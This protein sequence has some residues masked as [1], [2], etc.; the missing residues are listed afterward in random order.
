MVVKLSHIDRFVEKPAFLNQ[1][2]YSYAMIHGTNIIGAKY[3]LAEALVRP[4]DWSYC[5]QLSK[6]EQPAYGCFALGSCVTSRAGEIPNWN[7]VDL[8]DR[9][10]T[11]GKGQQDILL[12]LQY[13][14]AKEHLALKAGGNDMVQVQ[15]ALRGVVT[16]SEKYTVA[17]SEHYTIRSLIVVWPDLS[18]IE[19]RQGQSAT[20]TPDTSKDKSKETPDD[21]QDDRPPPD[22]LR[23]W[24]RRGDQFDDEDET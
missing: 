20:Y 17:R 4:A 12:A 9:A 16:T 18:F 2:N 5:E 21:S 6:C 8:L 22:E 10:T 13:K 15:C 3:C 24:N 23:S 19:S 14:G 1:A 11:K 7:L